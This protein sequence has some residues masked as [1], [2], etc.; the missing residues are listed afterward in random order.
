MEV[1]E[2]LSKRSDFGKWRA[3]NDSRG[4]LYMS[5][6]PFTYHLFSQYLQ[7]ILIQSQLRLDSYKYIFTLVL[8]FYKEL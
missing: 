4:Y 1:A 7:V 6:A 2:Q 8:S 3:M 5:N